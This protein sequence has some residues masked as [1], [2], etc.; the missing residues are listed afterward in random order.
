M[1]SSD[2]HNDTIAQAFRDITRYAC[3]TINP[4]PHLTG[5]SQ[6][7][8]DSSGAGKSFGQPGRKDRG[9]TERF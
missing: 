4:C 5:W 2:Q 9:V 1:P 6:W 8:N 7:R 3:K